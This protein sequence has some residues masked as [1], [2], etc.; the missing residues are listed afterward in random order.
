M[1]NILGAIGNTPIVKLQ[2]ITPLGC[3]E[4]YVKLEANNPTGS[5]KDR[6]ALSMIEG[7]SVVEYSGGSTGA[8]LAL[9]CGIKGYRFKLITADVFGNEKIA[10]MRALGADL[11]ILKSE[12][13]KITRE[14]I[15]KMIQ[16]AE[17]ISVEPNTFFTDQLNNSDVIEGFVPLGEEILQQLDGKVDAICD[18]IGTA[19]TLMGI[20]KSFKDKGVNSKIVALEPASSPILSKG[21]KGA[22]NVEGVGLGFIPAIYNSKYVDDVIAIEESLARQTCKELASK[23]GIFCGTSSGMNIAGAIKLSKNLG[24]KSKVVAVACDTGLKYLSEGLFY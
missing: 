5:K 10:L 12:D 1:K 14:L 11:E 2:K 24:P 17:E 8:G 4:V 3:G 19:G 6:M 22:H 15:S 21:I 18:T 13:G 7:M 16:R 20:A 9:V 23:E